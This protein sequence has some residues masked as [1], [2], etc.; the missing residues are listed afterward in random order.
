VEEKIVW[1]NGCFDIIHKGHIELF[2][3]AKS[4]GSKLYVGVDSDSR[5]RKLKGKQRPINSEEDRRSVLD[6]IKYIDK[7]FVFD[8]GIQLEDLIKQINPSVL[9]VGSDWRGKD[10][11]GGGHAKSVQF[12]ERVGGYST[13]KILESIL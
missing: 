5:V 8:S 9:V 6:S 3:Y 12:F 13:T 2:R 11:I 7:T 10:V 4:L 1:T